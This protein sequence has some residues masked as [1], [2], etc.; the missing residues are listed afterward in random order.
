MILLTLVKLSKCELLLSFET[1]DL[2]ARLYGGVVLSQPL[3]SCP[4]S[5]PSLYI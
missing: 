1:L 2:S 5:S 3:A 4:G